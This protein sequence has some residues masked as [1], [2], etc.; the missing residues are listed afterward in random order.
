MQLR[1]GR[2]HAR[3]FPALPCLASRARLAW[4]GAALLL[5]GQARRRA[6]VQATFHWR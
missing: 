6:R 4:P 1:Q 3:R 2:G 5:P